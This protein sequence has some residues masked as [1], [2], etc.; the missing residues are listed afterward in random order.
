MF[1]EMM[2]KER[3]KDVNKQSEKTGENRQKIE[4]SK[5]DPTKL[6][7]PHVICANGKIYTILGC[8]GVGQFAQVYEAY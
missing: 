1:Q 4:P 8:L 6:K 5:I 3:P 2:I 7:K